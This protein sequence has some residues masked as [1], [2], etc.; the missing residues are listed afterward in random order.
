M[1]M[2]TNLIPKK[3]VVGKCNFCAD[4]Y[5]NITMP[6]VYA[7]NIGMCEDCIK[8]IKETFY[9]LKIRSAFIKGERN[10]HS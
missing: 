8:T 3:L 2:K 10:D 7:G 5:D 9:K 1:P 4:Q 6:V